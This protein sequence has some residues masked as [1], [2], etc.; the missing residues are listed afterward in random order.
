MGGALIIPL[1][2]LLF[3]ILLLLTALLFDAAI[4]AWTVY[5]TWHDRVHWHSHLRR[6]DHR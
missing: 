6:V 5:R 2:A 1:V 4:I 3:P